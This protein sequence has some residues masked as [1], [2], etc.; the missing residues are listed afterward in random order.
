MKNFALPSWVVQNVLPTKTINPWSL[1]EKSSLSAKNTVPRVEE[2]VA[3]QICYRQITILWLHNRIQILN[4]VRK[5]WN[6]QDENKFY[7]IQSF[8]NFLRLKRIWKWK[9]FDHDLFNHQRIQITNNFGHA[10][11]ILIAMNHW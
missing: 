8:S 2:D 5:Y 3:S 10:V 11:G 6:W 4:S 1:R 7:L 9:I